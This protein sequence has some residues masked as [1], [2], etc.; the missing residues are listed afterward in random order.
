MKSTFKSVLKG[1][2]LLPAKQCHQKVARVGSVWESLARVKQ[3]LKKENVLGKSC[4]LFLYSSLKKDE[5]LV[6]YKSEMKTEVV[7]RKLN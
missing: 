6:T 1:C 2:R 3:N 7:I 5:K 4:T